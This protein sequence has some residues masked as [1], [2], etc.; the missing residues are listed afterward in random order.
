MTEGLAGTGSLLRLALRRDRVML[1]LWVALF[2]VMAITFVLAA[3][4]TLPIRAEQRA[5]E[6]AAHEATLAG[7]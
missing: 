7:H 6:N 5:R 2:V 1:P 3:L 4:F